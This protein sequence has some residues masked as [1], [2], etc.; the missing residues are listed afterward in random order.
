MSGSELPGGGTG[1]ST[2]SATSALSVIETAQRPIRQPADGGHLLQRRHAADLRRHRPRRITRAWGFQISNI[3]R[4]LQVLHGLGYVNQFNLFRSRALGPHVQ[5]DS[6]FPPRATRGHRAAE[7][8]EDGRGDMVPL[9]ALPAVLP[10][11]THLLPTVSRL[12]YVSR[13]WAWMV[14]RFT[15]LSSGRDDGP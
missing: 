1:S 10:L 8:A 3:S 13:P 15:G 6:R 2:C 5:A 4:A 7:Y 12:R 11:Y 9:G 14:P